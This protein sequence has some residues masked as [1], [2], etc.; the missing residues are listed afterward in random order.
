MPVVYFS[1]L[2]AFLLLLPTSRFPSNSEPTMFPFLLHR[3]KTKQGT[4]GI[5]VAGPGTGPEVIGS[6]ESHGKKCTGQELRE[7]E[8]RLQ[9]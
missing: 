3:I 6:K 9:K 1:P 4:D 5:A 2:P 8:S 7:K